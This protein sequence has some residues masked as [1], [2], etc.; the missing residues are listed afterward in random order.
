MPLESE[1]KEFEQ[2][3][4]EFLVHYH[5]LTTKKTK[6]EAAKARKSLQEMS[7]LIKEMRKS[8]MVY[9]NKI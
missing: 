8:I 5:L 9:K 3:H 6:S 7:H 4:R 2:H 1:F